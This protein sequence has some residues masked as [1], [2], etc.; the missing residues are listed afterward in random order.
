MREESG[1]CIESCIKPHLKP[2]L[3][4]LLCGLFLYNLLLDGFLLGYLSTPQ[5]PLYTSYYKDDMEK[6]I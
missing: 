2:A 4:F 6:Y 1:P 3:G 5:I